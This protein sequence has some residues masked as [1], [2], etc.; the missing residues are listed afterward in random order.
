MNT[1]NKLIACSGI[2]D[3]TTVINCIWKQSFPTDGTMS[4]SGSET[5]GVGDELEGS[6]ENNDN[7]TKC[8]TLQTQ[9]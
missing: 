1:W 4:N 7:I 8:E 2:I 6:W 5:S 3:S 9:E